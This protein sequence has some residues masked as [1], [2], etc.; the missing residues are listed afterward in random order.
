MNSKIQKELKFNQS[1]G[2]FASRLSIHKKCDSLSVFEI[3]IQNVGGDQ[4]EGV[5][6]A[7]PAVGVEDWCDR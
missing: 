7:V 5:W 3:T 1:S 2:M 6:R 4:G